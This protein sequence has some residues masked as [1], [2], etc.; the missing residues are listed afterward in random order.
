MSFLD[1]VC[2]FVLF[3][4]PVHVL[5]GFSVFFCSFSKRKKTK[6]HTKSKKDKNR[7]M[8][9]NK[10]THEIQEGHVQANEKEQKNTQNPRTC[11]GK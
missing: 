10:R 7:Q 4:L 1:L 9:K 8:K 2:P 11:T 5:L 3:H 6:G